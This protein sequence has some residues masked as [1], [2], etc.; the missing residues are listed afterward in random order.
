MSKSLAAGATRCAG[1]SPMLRLS[2]L[3][4]SQP[5]CSVRRLAPAGTAPP[6][7]LGFDCLHRSA[8]L[9]HRAADLEKSSTTNRQDSDHWVARVSSPLPLYRREEPAP[10]EYGTSVRPYTQS[11]GE[12]QAPAGHVSITL[13]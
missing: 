9:T 11:I 2:R 13:A 8:A 10:L 6:R 1:E 3:G 12:R 7:L 5:G 4:S